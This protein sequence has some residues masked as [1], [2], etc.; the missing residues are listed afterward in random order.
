MKSYPVI[1][2]DYNSKPWNKDPVIFTNQD[3]SRVHVS[4]GVLDV[5]IAGK[6][7]RNG[8]EDW[9]IKPGFFFEEFYSTHNEVHP[10]SLT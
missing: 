2:R 1:Y 4:Q 7:Q 5:L 10:Q 3:D 8:R 6:Q 9:R